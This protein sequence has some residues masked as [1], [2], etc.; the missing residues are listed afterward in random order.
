MHCDFCALAFIVVKPATIEPA[1]V[2]VANRLTVL[3]V[4][5]DYWRSAFALL[6]TSRGCG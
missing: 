5:Q 2:D 4:E 1:V 3:L 6:Y